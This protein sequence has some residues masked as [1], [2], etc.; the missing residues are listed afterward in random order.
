MSHHPAVMSHCC[1]DVTM[2]AVL[3][4][5]MLRPQGRETSTI[6]TLSRLHYYTY[7]N[8]HTHTESHDLQR[9]L[10]SAEINLA[11]GIS[12]TQLGRNGEIIEQNEVT[13]GD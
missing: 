12:F 8:K 11:S 2:N 7:L 9:K 5:T 13:H 4:V 1:S 3:M 10:M 6:N